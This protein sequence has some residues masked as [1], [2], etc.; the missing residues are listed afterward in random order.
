[1]GPGDADADPGGE[2]DGV[3]RGEGDADGVGDV[4]ARSVLAAATFTAAATLRA[5]PRC[6]RVTKLETLQ[7]LVQPRTPQGG[8]QAEPRQAVII[9][10]TTGTSAFETRVACDSLRSRLL[11][12]FVRMCRF[13]ERFRLIFPVAVILNR[14]MADR[15]VFFLIL[16]LVL[17]LR[18]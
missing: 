6:Q 12:F 15:F 14:A 7:N 18:M 2:G 1:V 3:G 4:D 13:I 16:V 9:F 5:I 10:L 17:G 11:A 8:R